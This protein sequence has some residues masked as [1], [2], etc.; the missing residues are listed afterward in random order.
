[1]KLYHIFFRFTDD[2]SDPRAVAGR[3]CW[4]TTSS[5]IRI[6]RHD[7]LSDAEPQLLL[8][9]RTADSRPRS[10]FVSFRYLQNAV[11]TVRDFALVTKGAHEGIVM[12]VASFIRDPKHVR[13]VISANLYDIGLDKS[14]ALPFRIDYVTR[15]LRIDDGPP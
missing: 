11:P 9:Y 15:L 8:S 10:S 4:T 3:L 1:M 13:R 2:C 6:Q 5:Q 12:K 7:S 14:S